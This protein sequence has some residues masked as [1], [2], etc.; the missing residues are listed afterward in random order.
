MA[1]KKKA[2]FGAES[3]RPCEGTRRS[4]ALRSVSF[5]HVYMWEC[6]IVKK[7]YSMFASYWCNV[8]HFLLALDFGDATETRAHKKEERHAAAPY[9]RHFSS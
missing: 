2:A 5:S 7:T 3:L 6:G 9:F 8:M 1:I 4:Y